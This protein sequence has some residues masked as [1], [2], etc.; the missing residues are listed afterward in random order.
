V[1]NSF[2][3]GQKLLSVCYGTD[4]QQGYFVGMSYRTD[5]VQRITVVME[6]GQMSGVPWAVVEFKDLTDIK[7]NL[8]LCVEVRLWDNKE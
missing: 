8:S 6:D 1:E 2:K 3:L 7:L 4:G 5:K